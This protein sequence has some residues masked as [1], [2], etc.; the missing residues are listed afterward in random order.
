MY[1]DVK[2]ESRSCYCDA[3][4]MPFCQNSGGVRWGGWGQAAFE[5]INLGSCSR[6]LVAGHGSYRP[7]PGFDD[8]VAKVGF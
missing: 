7:D 3:E 2:F 5:A 6:G 8:G 1:L 4:A